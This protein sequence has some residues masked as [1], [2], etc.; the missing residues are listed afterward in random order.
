MN[1]LPYLF[2]PIKIKSMEVK[3]RLVMAPMGTNLASQQGEATPSLISYYAARARGGVGLI[4]T[5]D[6]TVTS[7]AIY[8]PNG[9]RLHEDCLVQSW[10]NLTQAVH[11]HGAKIAPQLIHPSFN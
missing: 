7:S 2:R 10:K 5:D 3:N 4:I 11:A 1:Q 8:H 9:L 6:T